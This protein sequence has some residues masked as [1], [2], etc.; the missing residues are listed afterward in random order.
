MPERLGPKI[1]SVH[2]KDVVLRAEH[3]LRLDET[4]P[5][6]GAP[7]YRTLLRE[8]DKLD[9]DLTLVLEHLPDEAA[10][11]AAT[12]YVRGIAADAGVSV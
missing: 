6:L 10:F 4:R 8:L 11:D 5:G 2:A 1:R 9:P 7:D 12:A 3:A